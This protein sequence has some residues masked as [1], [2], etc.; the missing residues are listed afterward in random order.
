M[1]LLPRGKLLGTENYRI[2]ASAMK[3][4]LQARNKFSFVDGSCLKASYASSN[5]LSTQWD[6]CNAIKDFES[7]YDKVDGSVIFNLLK[8]IDNVKQGGSSVADHYHRLNF[9]WREFDALTKLPKCVCEP[10]R[11]ALLTRDPLPEVKDEYTT[12]SKE[13]SH[14]GIPESSGVSESKLNAAS[15]VVKSFNNNRSFKRNNNFGKQNFNANV[16]VKVNDKQ[17]SASTSSGFTSEQMQKLLSLIN[18]SPSSSIHANMA[19][20]AFFNGANQHLTVSTVGMFNVVDITSLNITVGYP[21]RT[22]ATI[23]HVGNLRLTNNVVQYDVLVVLGYIYLKKEK[24]MGIGSESGGLYLFDMIKDNYVGKSN[25]VMCFN[26]FKV[27]W[28]NRLGHPSDQVLSMLHQDLDISK[29]VWAYLIKTKD[30]VLDVFVSFKIFV[31]NQL[32]VKIKTAAIFSFKSP[33]DDGRATPV[34]DGSESPFRYNGTD[35][36][37]SLCQEEN[38]ATHFGDQSSSE[39]NFSQN[40]LGQ[41]LSV[42]ETGLEDVMKSANLCFATNL[43][44]STGPSCLSDALSDPNW[45]DAM[46]NEIEALNRNN[47]WTE[48]DFPH[49]RKP[50]GS[51]LVKDIYMTLPDGYN[52]ESRSKVY[53][54]NKSL[55][56]LKQAPRQWHAKLTTALVEHGFEQSKFDY[57]LYV[58]HKGDVFVALL[59]YV[60]NIVIIGNDEVEINNF[61]KFLSSKFLIKYLGELKYLLGIEVLK[62]DKGLCMTQRKY[63]LELLHEYG[64]LAA[65][66]VSIPFPKNSVLNHVEFKDD[67][68]LNNF[69][70]YQKLIGKFIYL[71]NTRPDISYV[72]H[73]LS[74]HMHSPLQSQM[75][76]VLRV[77]RYLKGSPGKS[78]TGFCVFLG[79]S[80]VSWK[81]K[82]QATLSRSSTKA[83][84]RNLHCDNS[85]AI[86]LVANPV[87]HE[88]SK[89]FEI[90][91]HFVREMVAAGVNKTV[92]VHTDLQVADILIVLLCGL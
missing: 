53:K 74:Q 51:D 76:E 31:N 38:I 12:V 7:T 22:L 19:G 45:V 41:S 32:D 34:E 60:D 66:S 65:R 70:S 2:W 64:L 37:S 84:Y 80:L 20:R 36:T 89:H 59:V 48:C 46:N 21:N 61:K 43:N 29:V 9:L 5:V 10:I 28:H 75:K 24:I 58:K 81:S 52:S 90:N 39:G 3:L 62:S 17:A 1:V 63:C 16:D 40:Y 14:R 15:F 79:K 13:E 56:G 11:G 8:K 85:Y 67:K 68:Y 82:K 44:K 42:N 49:G 88:K 6:I 83:E 55:Y 30:E 50:I 23:S 72:V 35:T 92:K 4:A 71:T 26:V 86:Q 69:T 77:L 27:L 91:V 25:M 54:L 33:N 87:F 57:S 73:C 47:T 78:V 18:D